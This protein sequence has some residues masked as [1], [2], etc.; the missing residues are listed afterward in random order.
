LQSVLNRF[1]YG[2]IETPKATDALIEMLRPVASQL[3]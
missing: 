1:L 2:E 3:P